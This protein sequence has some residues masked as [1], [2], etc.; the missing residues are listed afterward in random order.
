[1][2][3]AFSLIAYGR[4]EDAE[5]ACRDS[6]ERLPGSANL[7]GLLGAIL[8]KRGRTDEA[9]S[10]LLR[11]IALEPEFA[12]PQ[13]D[14]G[15]LYLQL[16][17][18]LEAISCFETAVRLDPSQASALLG[19]ATALARCGRQV[20]A[21]AARAR[22]LEL[23]PVSRALADAAQ[24]RLDGE[25]KRAEKICGEILSKDSQNIRAL[26]LLAKIASDDERY[27]AAEGLLRRV[28]DLAPD[29][30]PGYSDLAGFLAERSRFH[31]AVG[32]LE[33]TIELRPAQADLHRMLADTLAIINKPQAALQSY[34]RCLALEPA[35]LPALMGRG[36]MQRIIGQRDAAVSSYVECTRLLPASGEAWWNLAS[37]RGYRF[38]AA[39]KQQMTYLL[40][41]ADI[42]EPSRIALNFAL[43]RACEA[44]SNFE[45]AWKYYVQGNA[46]KR[47]TIS[48][49]PVETAAQN[50]LRIRVFSPDLLQRLADRDAGT[51]TSG[52]T[53]VFIVGMPRSG[54]TLIEQILASHSQAEGCGELP[55]VIMLSAMIGSRDP[56]G[57]KYPEILAELRQD[58][59][60]KLGS[61]YLQHSAAHRSATFRFFTDKMP[62]NFMHVGLIHLMLPQA[63]IIDARRDPM[64]ACIGNFRQLFAQG[65]N[66][67][68]D[69]LELGEY[70]LEYRRLMDHWDAVLP[71]RVLKV[72]YEDLV[73]DLETEVRRILQHCGL[74]FEA[75]CLDFHSSKRSV[76]TA[77]SEQVRLPIYSDAVGFWKNYESHVADLKQILEPVM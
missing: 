6:L 12:K 2:D 8:L 56:H 29:F 17:K 22:Y 3:N 23:S 47:R 38:S 9:Q 76:N 67:S 52:L 21:D 75:A 50:D 10:V 41:S 27:A 7:L 53:P 62:A 61:D 59:L 77:S 73:R 58:E 49:D 26:R 43:A 60:L 51:A 4:I 57:P 1:M 32:V 14:L 33:K 39:D 25:A 55:Y 30:Q 44:D 13:E 34:E 46:A 35:H 68:Y 48:Y 20:E 71:G 72:Q 45:M 54:S 63:I 19:L 15:T 18:P 42:D 74:P 40:A 11:T 66:Q 65:K 36:H 28:I 24:L 64:D 37:I 69:L 70:Y 31:E 16:N 5:Q